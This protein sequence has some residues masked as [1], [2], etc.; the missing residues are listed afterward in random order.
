MTLFSRSN[1]EGDVERMMYEQFK[2]NAIQQI[3]AKYQRANGPEQMLIPHICVVDIKLIQPIFYPKIFG[4]VLHQI[5]SDFEYKACFVR[6]NAS[7]VKVLVERR[8]DVVE[9]IE[10]FGFAIWFKIPN[11]QIERL[12]GLN[13]GED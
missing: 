5:F 3:K 7:P 4:E 2:T 13:E 12:C 6:Y 8:I 10:S 11:K 1:L 9:N